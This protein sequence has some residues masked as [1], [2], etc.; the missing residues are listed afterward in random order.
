MKR[1]RSGLCLALFLALALAWVTASG[2]TEPND[3]SGDYAGN[4]LIEGYAAR[5]PAGAATLARRIRERVRELGPPP[6]DTGPRRDLLGPGT[7]ADL[8]GNPLI[9]ALWKVDPEE[10]LCL[11]AR[12]RSATRP[13]T[14]CLAD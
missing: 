8:D 1:L 13:P 3:I 5:D 11:L 14:S 6:T 4:P 7:R 9:D 10:A 12:I 2:A